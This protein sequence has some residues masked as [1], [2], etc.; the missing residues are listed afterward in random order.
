VV[1][2]FVEFSQAPARVAGYLGAIL[3]VLAVVTALVAVIV[4]ATS[5]GSAGYWFV[6]AAVLLTGGLNLG[7]L[8]VMGEYVWRAG[9]D[10]R[11]RPIYVMR[12]VHDVVA[13]HPA[14][15]HATGTA[16]VTTVETTATALPAVIATAAGAHGGSAPS[17]S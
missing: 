11:R 12:S 6:T 1:D 17:G 10:A 3:C 9:D 5:D 8:S 15:P 7:F 2:S 4:A 16:P 13:H 14:V